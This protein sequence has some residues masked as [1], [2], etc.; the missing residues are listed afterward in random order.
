MVKLVSTLGTSPG[1]VFETFMNLRQGKYEAENPVPVDIKEVYVIRTSDP[2]VERAF[3][4]LKAIFAC[5]GGRE[6]EVA[7]IP[8]A[9]N[10]INTRSDYLQF[11]REVL[12]RI[13]PGD[14]VDFTGGR[15]AMSVAA[16]LA[17]RQ[18]EA[19]VVTSIIPQ[20]DYNEIQ[21][22]MKDFK[23]EDI[24]E[25]ENGRCKVDFCVLTSRNVKTIL[26]E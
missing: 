2:A 3:R 14:Y 17:A 10:D 18:R 26:L 19:H 9:M 23:D 15:K 20:A 24:L 21:S 8:L 4:L 7:G 16:V 5:C 11:R 1:G 6:V 13:S 25:G 22:K 12:S